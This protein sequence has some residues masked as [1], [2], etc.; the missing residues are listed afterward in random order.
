MSGRIIPAIGEP[1]IPPSVDSA[2]ELFCHLWVCLLAYRLG[3]KV[4][5]EFDLSS[6][7]QLILIG[8]CY[9][10]MLCHSFKGCALPPFPSC[11]MVLSSAPSGPTVL[12][13]QSSGGITR[14][15]LVLGGKY[16]I[17]SNPLVL[18]SIGHAWDLGDAQ[19]PA[20]GSQ[21]VITR[22]PALGS[23]PRKVVTPQ[24]AR[25]SASPKG[26]GRS[27]H[28]NLPRGPILGR[29]PCLD[30]PGDSISRRPQPQP[31]WRSASWSEDAWLSG[32]DSTG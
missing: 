30:L 17:I 24:P 8:L 11:F 10:P 16:C 25:G 2:W 12:P 14:K 13:L 27:S 23:G 28:L 32:C 29:K 5:L 7:T 22:W 15:Y 21:E 18:P 19:T 4:W 31:P 26:P 9:T 1:P 6:W 20:R 3:I